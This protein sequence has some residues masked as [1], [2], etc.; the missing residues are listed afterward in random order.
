MFSEI[1][2]DHFERHI[3]APE[4]SWLLAQWRMACGYRRMPR[5]GD[6]PQ[7]Q[8]A[9]LRPDLIVLRPLDGGDFRFEHYGANITTQT[10]FDMTGKRVSEFRGELGGFF[11]HVYGRALRECRPIA[12]VHR[13]GRFGETPLWERLI[14]PCGMGETVTCLYAVVK[15]RE[16][17]QDISHLAARMR[18]RALIVLQFERDDQNRIVDA[19][20]VGANRLAALATHRRTDELVGHAMLALFPGLKT[21]GLW[22]RYLAVAEARIPQRLRVPYHADGLNGLFSVEISPMLDGVTVAFEEITDPHRMRVAQRGGG[23]AAEA[24]A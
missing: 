15:A 11:L 12:A 2:D 18:N 24:A 16:I 6:I 22:E 3:Q 19:I 1:F 10:G 17:A 8:L 14:L 7:A 20:I 9:Y 21:A 5:E 13:F 4:A 23:P